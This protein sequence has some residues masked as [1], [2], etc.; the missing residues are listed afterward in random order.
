MS[1]PTHKNLSALIEQPD[2]RRRENGD[3]QTEVRIY[4]ADY[5]T[6]KAAQKVKN[7]VGT[8]DLTGYII[9]TSIVEPIRGL[10]AKLIDTWVAGGD[11]GNPETNPL[12]SDEVALSATNQSPRTERHPR[13]ISLA[14]IE[15]ELANVETA[16]RSQNKTERNAAYAALSVLGKELVD[17]LR[18]GNESYYLATLRYSWA[19]HS[20]VAPTSTSG[21]YIESVGGPLKD[22]FVPG[23]QWLR[24]ADNL[25]YSGGIWRLTRSWLGARD[26]SW[27]TDL[28]PTY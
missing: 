16:T 1:S 13:Y 20:Y 21:G 5:D 14:G 3:K 18:A 17:K 9:T 24:E 22:Y 23:I 12:P 11:D 27:D 2:S 15:D 4:I 26:F 6:C 7:T 19:T 25:D 10:A 28:Y 8:G